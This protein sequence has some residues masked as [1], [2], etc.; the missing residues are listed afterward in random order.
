MNR[1]GLLQPLLVTGV[2]LSSLLAP[3]GPAGAAPGDPDRTFGR[4]GT[5]TTDFDGGTDQARAVVV[6]SDGKVVAAG[7]GS[8]S[9]AKRVGGEGGL[10]GR[11]GAQ[12]ALARYG[13][14]GS[15]DPTFGGDGKVTTDIAGDDAQALA[16][17]LQPDGNIVAA[18]GAVVD[19]YG[20]FALARY[21]PDGALDPTFAGDGTLTT[22]LPGVDARAFALAVQP[23][24]KLVAAGYSY[25]GGDSIQFA[26]ARYLPD[27]VLDPDFGRGGIVITDFAGGTDQAR[28]LVVQPDGKLVAAGF[29]LE[30]GSFQFALARYQPD[31]RLDTGFGGDG[32]VTTDFSGGDDQAFGIGLQ[33]DGRLVAAGG[34]LVGRKPLS[35]LPATALT[36][37]DEAPHGE[38]AVARYLPDGTLDTSFDGDGRQ[39]TRFGGPASAA[40]LLLEPAGEIV[41]V[42]FAAEGDR[43]QFALARYLPHGGLDPSF[44][45]DGKLT[46]AVAD[47]ECEAFAVARQ[48]D[49]KLVAAGFAVEGGGFQFALARYESS[50]IESGVR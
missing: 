2:L 26:L 8:I 3:P 36:P 43:F 31:G 28:A 1:R 20:E 50:L 19:G 49:R 46:A 6:Q 5:L 35:G 10:G 33:P 37:P 39:T 32:T 11:G 29:A 40:A 30:K 12:F 7:A 9:T 25:E 22:D 4:D 42:G 27:G 18:G 38:F 47:G 41:T 14:D 48:P 15:L 21:L 34:A 16:V 23:D 45:G 24:G 44:S 17:V 13:P